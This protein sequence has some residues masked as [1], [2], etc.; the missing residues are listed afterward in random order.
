MR[1][2]ARSA[3]AV[4]LL[5]A[6]PVRLPA[7]GAEDLA[8]LRPVRPAPLEP[9]P[10]DWAAWT[11]VSRMHGLISFQLEGASEKQTET[12]S[13]Q[14][15]S[16][17]W[18]RA[19]VELELDRDLVAQS[20]QRRVWRIVQA[21]GAGGMASTYEITGTPRLRHQGR[22]EGEFA[23][24]LNLHARPGL[25]LNLRNGEWEFSTDLKPLS[26]GTQ[27]TTFNHR[28]WDKV[29]GDTSTESWNGSLGG[30]TVLKAAA[31]RV[32]AAFGTSASRQIDYPQGLD[33]L[34]G[35]GAS[36]ITARAEFWPVLDDVELKVRIAD[37]AAWRPR[38]NIEH[39][40]RP[41]GAPL[42]VTAVLR[43]K[44]RGNPP[45]P[46]IRE[47]SFVLL[48]TSREPGVCLNWPLGAK[49]T[50]PDLR[51]ALPPGFE[52]R[53]TIVEDGQRANF[54]QLGPVPGGADGESGA[55]VHVDSLDFGAH[56]T[57]QV[58][59]RLMDGRLVTGELDG[60][61][62]LP[63]SLIN[64]PYSRG[65]GWIAESWIRQNGLG[66]R[67]E[68]T[69]DENQP[70]GDGHGGDG[71]TLYEEYRGWVV[72]GR[73]VSGDPKKKEVFVLNLGEPA[74]MNGVH[75]FEVM[76]GLRVHRLKSGE[77]DPD[78]RAMNANRAKGPH[79]VLQHGIVLRT[80]PSLRGGQTDMVSGRANELPG[81]PK[82]VKQI[83]VGPRIP[84][85]G[86]LAPPGV[87]S[88]AG[89]HEATIAHELLHAVG[90]EHHGEGDGGTTLEYRF[91]D[92]PRAPSAT[93]GFWETG[94]GVRDP[95]SMLEEDGTDYARKIAPAM[96]EMRRVAR[97]LFGASITADVNAAR[98][99]RAGYTF[100]LTA[101]QMIEAAINDVVRQWSM[102]RHL[103]GAWQ[104]QGSGDTA[105]VMRYYFSEIYPKKGDPS[106]YYRV[107]P[108]SE[109][110]GGFICR[111]ADGTGINAPDR[112][113]QPR[114]G[115]AAA[116]RGDCLGQLCVND[117]IPPKK[118]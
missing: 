106:T 56:A 78:K 49:D 115:P 71:F 94:L 22:T 83:R 29:T 10:A 40:A 36:R 80:D 42:A 98:A 4:A 70:D 104:G 45:P 74:I 25:A 91:A 38:G 23:G 52:S 86:N 12:S 117:A 57:L 37:Y 9:L 113:P 72:D 118:R 19:R 41:G 60:H 65:D 27:T 2:I 81:R 32:A 50:A 5:L 112:R 107:S 20:P 3:A 89:F 75:S 63:A 88:I 79:R 44:A 15:T 48:G 61:E 26:P 97:D 93:P 100:Q 43:S 109:P 69:D 46:A 108:H 76:T 24:P 68:N 53:G 30:H 116:N 110:I 54:A 66:L 64:L 84:P 90:V 16:A 67:E 8:P 39:P 11:A 73:H 28:D 34:G 95:V 99:A 59:A 55:F 58:F 102:Q 85:E 14:L 111:S 105:C 51:L 114:Y 18:F 87:T 77:M 62:N 21:Q 96:E 101:E 35:P 1:D 7:Q 31:P 13:R 103:V 6:A 92:D 47:L 82:F 17:E 33:G